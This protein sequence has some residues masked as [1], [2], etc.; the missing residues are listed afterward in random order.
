MDWNKIYKVVKTSMEVLEI[1]YENFGKNN[2]KGSN[3]SHPSNSS[4]K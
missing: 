3:N 4:G 2:S 1:V